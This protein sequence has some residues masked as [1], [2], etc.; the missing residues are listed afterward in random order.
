MTTENSGALGLDELSTREPDVSKEA[1]QAFENAAVIG[2]EKLRS[3]GFFVTGYMSKP[4][5]PRPCCR[6]SISCSVSRRR[7]GPRWKSLNDRS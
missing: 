1:A 6:R 7:D 5:S 2:D 4:A 3:S